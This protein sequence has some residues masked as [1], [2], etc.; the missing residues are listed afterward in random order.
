MLF[1]AKTTSERKRNY[2]IALKCSF[3]ILFQAN[4]YDF[5]RRTDEH[6]NGYD[7]NNTHIRPRDGNRERNRERNRNR[8][9]ERDM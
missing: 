6:G 8:D 5:F 4:M 2:W 7:V 3:G 9:R 1:P